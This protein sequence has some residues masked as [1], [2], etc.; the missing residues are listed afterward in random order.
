M[1]KQRKKGKGG[2]S[3]VFI[4]LFMAILG[5][6]GC[7]GSSAEG[8]LQEPGDVQRTEESIKSEASEIREEGSTTYQG[9]PIDPVVNMGSL[10]DYAKKLEEA[11]NVEA[12]E[13]VYELL[14]HSGR[15]MMEKA[16]E[17]NSMLGASEELSQWTK[18]LEG[19]KGGEER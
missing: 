8:T 19:M 10:M 18:V 7:M 4:L 13:A 9:T 6:T 14:V 12:A 16:Y 1:A 3:L 15:E 2:R 17:T 11:G 5:I